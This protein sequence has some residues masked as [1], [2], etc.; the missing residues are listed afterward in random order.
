VHP[1]GNVLAVGPAG[2]S[3]LSVRLASAA[4]IPDCGH[5]RG[6]SAGAGESDYFPA[7]EGIARTGPRLA[8]NPPGT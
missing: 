5:R 2:V 1:V 4:A 6:R 7:G 8:A 3:A